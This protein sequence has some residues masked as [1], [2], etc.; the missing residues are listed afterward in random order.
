MSSQV[1]QHI[2]DHIIIHWSIVLIFGLFDLFIYLSFNWYTFKLHSIDIPD[3]FHSIFFR[4]LF[5]QLFIT[6]PIFYFT[7]DFSEGSFWVVENF[8]RIPLTLFWHEIFFYYSHRLLHVPFFYKHI[9]KVHHRWT[10]PVAISATYAHPI[11]H[12]VSNILPILLS[13]KIT[14]MNYSTVRVWHAFTLIHT[15]IIAHGGYK[16][17]F[18]TNMH[19]IH[20]VYF[21]CNYGTS[22]L[23]DK[24]HGTIRR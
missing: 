24:I 20:H 14:T 17:P 13:A 21:N 7:P 5:N 18:Y 23:F 2:L 11:E 3:N 8:Y 12:A 22:G 9:H 4:V 1:F 6:F 16:I 15:M 10:A 19:D